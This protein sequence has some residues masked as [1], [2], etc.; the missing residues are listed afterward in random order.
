MPNADTTPMRVQARRVK[1]LAL[2]KIEDILLHPENYDKK[3][4]QELILKIA[5]NV[6]PRT[7]EV[8][9]EDGEAINVQIVKYGDPITSPLSTTPIP[10][11]IIAS[12]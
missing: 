5:G 11:P 10:D 1:T 3:F 7:Q 8:T 9:G 12:L 4:Y 2:T 6:V